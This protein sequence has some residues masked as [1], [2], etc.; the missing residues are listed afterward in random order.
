MRHRLTFAAAVL[1]ALALTGCATGQTPASAPAPAVATTPEPAAAT[2]PEPTSPASDVVASGSND[3]Q[4]R[5]QAQSWLDDIS[6]PPGTS[7]A[8]SNVASFSSYTGWPCGPVSELEAFWLVPDATLSDTADWLDAHPAGGLRSVWGV[9]RPDSMDSDGMTLGYIPEE[10]AQEGIVYT[11]LTVPR[12]IAVRA[13]I[14]AQT[15]DASCPELPD[16]GQYG[17]PGMG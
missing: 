11:L 12:G 3:E 10:G 9:H 16:G 14:A 15:F 13:E 6:L 4:A 2:T 17:A 1:A 8:R 7:P 5:A